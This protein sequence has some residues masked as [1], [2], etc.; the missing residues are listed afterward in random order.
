MV[1]IRARPMEMIVIL[2]RLVE[3]QIRIDGLLVNQVGDLILKQLGLRRPDPAGHAPQHF[4]EQ[5]NR[6]HRTGQQNHMPH[7]RP[8]AVGARGRKHAVHQRPRQVDDGHRQHTL[9][10]E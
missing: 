3:R 2:G 5:N 1:G 4:D 7:A 9:N 8:L 10:D 6:G